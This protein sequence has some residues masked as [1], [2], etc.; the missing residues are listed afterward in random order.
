MAVAHSALWYH[1]YGTVLVVCR[2]SV[3]TQQHKRAEYVVQY[4]YY[5]PNI[6][7]WEKRS[8]IRIQYVMETSFR[9]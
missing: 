4:I 7:R 6:E 5:Q 3:F 1:L 2:L 9:R 8:F